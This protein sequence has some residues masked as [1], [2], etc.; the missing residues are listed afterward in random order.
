MNKTFPFES[1]NTDCN[2]Q[3]VLSIVANI[4]EKRHVPLSVF[5]L[6]RILQQYDVKVDLE[7]N[8]CSGSQ[9]RKLQFIMNANLSCSTYHNEKY[10]KFVLLPDGTYTLPH[11]QHMRHVASLFLKAH[12]FSHCL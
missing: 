4:L 10:Q 2:D 6:S 1:T 3:Q 12:Y 11:I 7:D 9:T 5:Q 8:W